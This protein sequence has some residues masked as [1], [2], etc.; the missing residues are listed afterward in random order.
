MSIFARLS[1]KSIPIIE[2]VIP[3]VCFLIAV[4][5]L[6]G[7]FQCAFGDPFGVWL[8]GAIFLW[9]SIGLVLS[10][11]FPSNIVKIIVGLIFC[12]PLCAFVFF[13]PATVTALH[14]CV[15]VNG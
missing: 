7:Y 15:N 3:I 14:S 9:N 8:L 5:F 2:F 11:V 4:S 1:T 12:I 6:P 13:I 10:F